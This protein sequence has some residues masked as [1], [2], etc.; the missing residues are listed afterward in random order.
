MKNLF[1]SP[2]L[3][4]VMVMFALMVSLFVP[5]VQATLKRA[6]T[7]TAYHVGVV[8]TQ[9]KLSA[10][11]SLRGYMAR[12]GLLLNAFQSTVASTLGFGVIGELAFD[13]PLRAQTAII[14]DVNAANIVVGRWFTLD[15]A[16]TAQA[17]G[18]GAIGGVLSSP[19]EYSTAGLAG[20]ALAPTLTLPTGT[21]GEFVYMGAIIVA[22]PAAVAIGAVGKYN[23]TTG[24]IGSGAPAG[25][26]AAIPNS[27][28]IRYP[29]AAAGLAVLEL[30][31]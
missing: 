24:V 6:A 31:N 27:K 20:N 16:G 11:E 7:L 14:N 19:K 25:G 8:L 17:G 13:G 23:T 12:G 4:A 30:T 15:A 5:A 26:E 28:F 2:I 21:V 3:L 18:T 22:L 10:G 1:T 29:N 9:A